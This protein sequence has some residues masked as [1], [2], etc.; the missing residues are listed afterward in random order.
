MRRAMAFAAG[1][2]VA[3]AGGGASRAAAQIADRAAL[4]QALDSAARAHV[5]HELVPGA[6]VAVVRGADTLLF[7]GYGYVDLEWMVPTPVDAS[8]SY[9]IGSVTKQFTAA[10]VLKLVERGLLDLDRDV[11]DYLPDF[12]THGHEVPLR[13]LLDHTSGIQGYT[14]MPVFWTE[15]SKEALPRDSL[16]ALFEAEPFL[17]EPGRGQIYNN[18]AY[19]L[20]GLVIEEVS[21]RPYEEF[22]STEIFEPLGMKGSYY[23]SERAIREGKAHGYDASPE[24][25]VVKAYLDHTWPYAA[26]SLCSTAG[27]LVRWNQALHGGRVLSPASYSS[28]TTPVPLLDGTP[29][30]YAMGLAIGERDGVREISHGGG[31]NGF[32]THGAYY[33]E[34]DLTVVVLQNA[35]SPRGPGLLGSA[36]AEMI[37]GPEVEPVAVPYPGDPN[38][39]VGTYA[40]PTRGGHLH[41]T[42]TVDGDGIVVRARGQDEGRR[43]IHVGDGVWRDGG[44]RYVFDVVGGR[45][46]G[47][48]IHQGAGRYPL[49]P[50]GQ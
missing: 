23:C 44:T 47:L 37:Y 28:M 20:L 29:L 1:L 39:L 4:V 45:P 13:R 11:T 35:G 7:R 30:D 27:D 32:L 2:V 17:F 9:E 49:R 14:E 43:P 22:L 5:D 41:L 25:L 8:A 19:F 10:A 40:G 31:I 24:G 6:S 36:I 46:I 50:V 15:L 21:G 48:M 3:H 18:S 16:V 42:V 38:L 26:G 33:P 12:D 34:D